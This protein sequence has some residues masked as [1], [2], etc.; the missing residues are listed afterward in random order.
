MG[1]NGGGGDGGGG[2]GG[3]GV[4]GGVGGDGGGSLQITRTWLV[5][6]EFVYELASG[7]LERV[8]DE[9]PAHVED[10]VNQ[11]GPEVQVLRHPPS[12]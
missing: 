9:L 12:G 7:Y 1:G 6:W 11:L 4:G 2:V 3:D 5:L 10:S 8:P